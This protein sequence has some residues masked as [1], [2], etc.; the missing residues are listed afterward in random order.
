MLGKVSHHS[1]W[2]VYHDFSSELFEGEFRS[3]SFIKLL[4]LLDGF[5]DK[6]LIL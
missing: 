1:C 2:R 5:K 4:G 3:I 6:R